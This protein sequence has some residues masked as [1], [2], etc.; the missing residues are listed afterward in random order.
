MHSV[1]SI[2]EESLLPFLRV[3]GKNDLSGQIKISGAKNS[4]LVLMAGALLTEENVHL[5]NVPNL[6]DIDVMTDLLLHI[7]ANVN[8]NTNQVLLQANQSDLSKNEL[9]YELV[10]ALRASFV[11]IGPLLA[12]LGEVK[13][14]L[15]G[16][17]RIGCRPID[18]H[19]QGLKALGASVRIDNDTVIAKIVNSRKRLIG[20]KIK[21]NC[22]SVGATETVL[23]AA[24]LAEGET[25][26][27]NAAQE[28]EIQDLANMLNKM[29][30]N[31]QGA[32]TSQIKIEG[33]SHLKGCVHDV[34]PDRIEAG[35]FLIASAITRCPLTISPVIP[36]HIG[37][38]IKKLK[39]CGCSI[40]KAGKGL[41]IFPGE[42]ISSVDMST[43]PFPG[44]PTDLQAPFMALMSIA[45]GTSKIEETVFERRMQHVGELQ[46]MGA[47]IS[48]SENTAFISGVNEL[49]ATSITGGDLRSSAAMVLASL[50]AKGTSVIQG[51][52]HLDRGYE[53]FEHKLS[54]VGA[55]IS[56]SPNKLKIDTK[57]SEDLQKFSS[58][59]EVA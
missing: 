36:E 34:I 24:T 4:A 12:R 53:N 38:V 48:L 22:K 7:G 56:R 37:A 30:A 16:G 44:F 46:R 25:I 51:L 57:S 15:P 9:P 47:Q 10:H 6:T 20:T 40:E 32:G 45:T 41:K 18:E 29:G 23:M 28:P 2:S 5:N 49:I 54:Q 52:N 19:I 42:K 58:G 39:Q 1:S 35:T 13:T 43:S 26:L 55:I 33:V 59:T 8:R 31:V 11:C 3:E 14:P 21:F 50:S 17:C 27:E